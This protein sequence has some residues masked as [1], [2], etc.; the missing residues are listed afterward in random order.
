[1]SPQ[2]SQ[3]EDAPQRYVYTQ[4]NLAADN[5]CRVSSLPLDIYASLLAAQV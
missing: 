1:M 4:A 5:M 3:G 2:K